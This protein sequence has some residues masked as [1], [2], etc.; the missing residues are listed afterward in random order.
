MTSSWP[1]APQQPLS[2]RRRQRVALVS[3]LAAVALAATLPVPALAQTT[4]AP[5]L[6]SGHYMLQR[7]AKSADLNNILEVAH[8][9]DDGSDYRTLIE[10]QPITSNTDWTLDMLDSNTEPLER[11]IRAAAPTQTALSL[12]VRFSDPLAVKTLRFERIGAWSFGPALLFSDNALGGL[13][14][15]DTLYVHGCSLCVYV[16]AGFIREPSL[17]CSPFLVVWSDLPGF[18]HPHLW[19]QAVRQL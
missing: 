2:R 13:T 18:F 9:R 5:S 6:S 7:S 1:L 12:D 10:F 11:T 17:F 4:P 14:S 16:L 19:L 8:V 3:A 15:L